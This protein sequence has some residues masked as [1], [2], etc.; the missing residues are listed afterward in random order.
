MHLLACII[1]IFQEARSSECRNVMQ[2]YVSSEYSKR[3]TG[4]SLSSSLISIIST[5]WSKYKN[6]RQINFTKVKVIRLF[7]RPEVYEEVVA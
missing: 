5:E 1:R 6:C 2:T 7:A 4:L 3:A